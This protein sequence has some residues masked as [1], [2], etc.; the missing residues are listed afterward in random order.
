[1][2]ATISWTPKTIAAASSVM[3][4]QTRAQI[5][6]AIV[7]VPKASIH[8]QCFPIRPI[9]SAGRDCVDSVVVVIADSLWGKPVER[10][11]R[12]AGRRR[13]SA[14]RV[15]V[16]GRHRRG[17]PS[18]TGDTLRP[19]V[20]RGWAVTTRGWAVT[21]AHPGERDRLLGDHR[22]HQAGGWRAEPGRGP[23]RRDVETALRHARVVFAA[24]G[25][26][27]SPEAVE[28]LAAALPQ[29]YR[30]LVAE[31]QL[32]YLEIMPTEQFWGRVGPPLARTGR[33]EARPVL[34]TPSHPDPRQE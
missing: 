18:R 10:K 12:R 6:A 2:P 23:R 29:I 14:D 27:L 11:V 22:G 34:G 3:P 21:C 13:T 31:A 20:A 26:T 17:G 4:G 16:R 9:A 28:H 1:M 32:R 33:A 7:R 8:P 19:R 25:R 5:P 24:L 30:P 15:V